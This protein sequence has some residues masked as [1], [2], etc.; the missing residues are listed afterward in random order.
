MKKAETM[1]APRLQDGDTIGIYSPSGAIRDRSRY[2]RGKQYL[3]SLGLNIRET[4][5]V[6]DW[7]S[8]YSADGRTKAEDFHTLILDPEVKVTIPSV[9]GHTSIQMIPFI[10]WELVAKHPKVH[11][12][13]SDNSL[14]VN[15]ISER[16]GLVTFH[17][18]ADV[19]YGFGEF[20]AV[21]KTLSTGGKFTVTDLLASIRGEHYPGEIRQLE[22]WR[23][24]RGGE[25][26]GFL[27]GGNLDTMQAILGTPFALDWKDT[28]FFW[29]STDDPH[30]IDLFLATLQMCGIL[31]QIV[32]MVVG[33]TTNCVEKFYPEK[34]DSVET[35]ILRYTRNRN[36]PVI[37]NADIGH[38]MENSCI[39]IGV[40]ASIHGDKLTVLEG[41]VK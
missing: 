11:I 30:R 22:Q 19:M 33:R 20:G 12:G 35:I 14:L 15:L 24:L 16:T 41:V 9:G 29:E 34:Y 37:V 26:K 17:S 8:H 4:A 27:K 23:V 18:G 25:A 31:D 39:P 21:N 3:S 13:F 32:G 36:Y 10:D 5:H 38:S 28:I 6:L 40:M 7:E 2:L 1:I